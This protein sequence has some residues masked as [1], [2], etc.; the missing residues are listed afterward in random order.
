MTKK[1]P[2]PV[3]LLIEASQARDIVLDRKL[4]AMTEAVNKTTENVDRAVANMKRSTANIERSADEM[5]AIGERIERQTAA[6]TERTVVVENRIIRPGESLNQKLDRIASLTERN[7]ESIER[8]ATTS[9][10]TINRLTGLVEK[11][12]EQ[13]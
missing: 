5:K 11:L 7:A 1:G 4:T 8:L 3:D 13:N 6:L 10:D 9:G 2:D 12:L